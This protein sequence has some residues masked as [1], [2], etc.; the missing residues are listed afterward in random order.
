MDT[1]ATHIFIS[2]KAV[3]KAGLK[4]IKRLTSAVSLINGTKLPIAGAYCD[5]LRITDANKEMRL[6]TV[7]LRC[8]D[9]Q[10]FDI[11]L[12][13]PLT[14]HAQPVF[15]WL[16]REWKYRSEDDGPKVRVLSPQAFY[17]SMHKPG[18]HLFA[19][20]IAPNPDHSDVVML[21]AR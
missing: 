10:G 1:G 21:E 14:T 15:H 11:V 4:P 20:S 8:L 17:T 6:Q 18:A 16:A 5:A 12:G 2:H 7:T 3:A 19:V 9:L 13:M